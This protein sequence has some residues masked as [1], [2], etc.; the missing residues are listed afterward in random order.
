MNAV[1]RQGYP[2]AESWPMNVEPSANWHPSQRHFRARKSVDHTLRHGIRSMLRSV[3]KR[4]D[5]DLP[6][7]RT[8]VELRHALAAA[9]AEAVRNLRSQGHSW[10]AIAD[11]LGITKQSAYER[12]NR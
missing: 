3:V 2:D 4:N 6:D 7:L 11:E 1:E 10:Q 12:F 8:L 5:F 9:E